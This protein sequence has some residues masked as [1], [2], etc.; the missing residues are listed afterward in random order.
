M[1]APPQLPP[2]PPNPTDASDT[3]NAPRDTG[4]LAR[5][6]EALVR[7][8]LAHRAATLLVLAALT[9]AFGAGLPKLHAAYGYHVL[10]GDDHPA[11]LK[12]DA[13]IEMFGGGQPIVVAWD[14]G[15]EA[16]CAHPLD[17]AAVEMVHD[18]GS[19][20]ASRGDVRRVASAATTSVIIPDEF[21]FAVRHLVE[22]GA[23]APDLDDLATRAYEDP[24][25]DGVLFN[26]D[27]RAGAFIVQPANTL[28]AT[29]ERLTDALLAAL[30]P[31]EARGFTFAIRGPAPGSVVGGRAL[32]QSVQR[33]IPVL[34][35][36]IGIALFA[37]A[38]SLAHTVVALVTMGVAL[39]WTFGTLGWLGWPQDGILQVLAPLV[40]TVGVCDAVHYLTRADELARSRP[41][42]RTFDEALASA[43][44][45]VG[46]ACLLTT[47]TTGVAF[48]SFATSELDTFLRFGVISAFGVL[49]CLVTTF[50]LLP[51][52]ASRFAARIAHPV[53]RAAARHADW[54]VGLERTASF[55]CDRAPAVLAIAAG[56]TAL[57]FV[58]IT[59]LEVDNDWV[60]SFG[61]D[62][63]VGIWEEGFERMFGHQ[64]TVD[65]TL[66]LPDAATLVEPQA[67]ASIGAI[68]E[69][70]ERESIFRN[71][72]GVT[73]AVARLNRALHEGN[74][75][76]HRV[77]DS[78]RANAELIEMLGFDDAE[79]LGTWLSVDRRTVRFMYESPANAQSEKLAA[80]AD[81]RRAIE[82]LLPPG[83]AYAFEGEAPTHSAFVADV[84]GTQ[85]RSFPVAGL[86]VWVLVWAFLRSLRLGTIA[87]VPTLIPVAWT[88]GLMGWLGMDLDIG[89]S[90]VAAVVIGIGVDDAIHLMRAFVG[91]RTSTN[92]DREALVV[93]IAR[94]GRALVS[95]TLALAAGFMV[96]RMAAWVTISSFGVL[97]AFTVSAALVCTLAIVPAALTLSEARGT[98]TR[99]LAE[100]RAAVVAE[101]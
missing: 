41:G 57:S 76:F 40:L 38:R 45:D 44:R 95:T 3:S 13:F 9:C 54:S 101:P 10:I 100:A 75:R 72:V 60:E 84:L 34:V 36:V 93:A 86:L 52:L 42:P 61:R 65:V 68:V 11:I 2:R 26:A 39:L 18:V 20:L 17:R 71:P 98:T 24:L 8:V 77:G 30:A 69:A 46:P 81:A 78:A 49:A 1:P 50:T 19:A 15:A 99:R 73:D 29:E 14:C 32:D 35:I 82:R 27:R 92:G 33:L 4:P 70:I 59:R 51:L 6:C 80:L 62:S 5:A 22:H 87:L 16:P 47:A 12:L 31:H 97:V 56:V 91:A 48:L 85:L 83:W 55:M 63:Q 64:S 21:G 28:P 66:T 67:L 89:R 37:M 43:A 94:T 23:L 96:L 79:T 53:E 74:E 58:G 25:W 90:M 7:G 88:L